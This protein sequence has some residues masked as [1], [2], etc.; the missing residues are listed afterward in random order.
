MANEPTVF[1][2]DDDPGALESL[3]WLIES[4]DLRAMPFQSAQEFLDAYNPT[5][6]G[7]LILDIRMPGMTGLE[8]Q[9]RL[10][11]LKSLL[12]II[13]VT[14]HGNVPL[15]S[16]ALK[17][18]AFEFLEKPVDDKVLLNRIQKALDFNTARR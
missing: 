3:V 8:L 9:E 4:I 7:C 5:V 15:C 10:S 13:I 11:Q 18:G 17:A 14:G 1:I 16:Q 2:V 12:P 6:P